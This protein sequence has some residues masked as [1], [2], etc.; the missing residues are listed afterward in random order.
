MITESDPRICQAI[1]FRIVYLIYYDAKL[2]DVHIH[3]VFFFFFFEI[4]ERRNISTFIESNW[5][6]YL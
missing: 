4:K 1:M 3:I 5:A 6:E 2:R